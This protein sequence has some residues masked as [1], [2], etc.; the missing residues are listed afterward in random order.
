[1]KKINTKKFW[2]NIVNRETILYG[3][4][5]ILTTVLNIGLYEIL[6]E[7][8]INYKLAN[9]ITLISTKLIA[10]IVNKLFV[11]ESRTGS[12]SELS[13][14]FGR[15]VMTRG[16]T[17]LIDYFGL[18]LLVDYLGC[19]KSICKYMTTSIVIIVNYFFGKKHVFVDS[20]HNI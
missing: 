10:Y 16:I 8:S 6:L 12:L 14:E 4:F 18:I 3:I 1:M 5:G 19:N 2:N 7:F 17:M 13:K 15:Y 20:K 9:L 11:F